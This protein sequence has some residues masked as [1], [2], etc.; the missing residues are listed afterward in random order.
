MEAVYS[1]VLC[2]KFL[3]MHSAGVLLCCCDINGLVLLFIA[4]NA[5]YGFLMCP[6][7]IYWLTRLVMCIVCLLY[8]V[9]SLTLHEGID[10]AYFG[11]TFPHLFLM[12]YGHLKPQ[13]S[14]QSYV[15]RVFGFKVHKS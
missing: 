14:S 8:S 10:G 4:P 12:T 7:I 11:T 15:P 9:T 13:M 2:V 5:L 1:C 6:I 3:T